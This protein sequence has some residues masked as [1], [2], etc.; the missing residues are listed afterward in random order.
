MEIIFFH[1][2]GGLSARLQGSKV[3][4]NLFKKDGEKFNLRDGIRV[5]L[6]ARELGELGLMLFTF[7]GKAEFIHK[8][9]KA[10]KRISFEVQSNEK[11]E[12]FL[13]VTISADDKKNSI[14][15]TKGEAYILWRMVNRAIDNFLAER[16]ER[17]GQRDISPEEGSVAEGEQSPAD[18]LV[19]L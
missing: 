15:L 18:E 3:R 5:S 1:S 10:T 9:E 17:R 4:L 11:G 19:S 2:K 6:D 14:R 8:T 7:R 12:P 13:N 16:S